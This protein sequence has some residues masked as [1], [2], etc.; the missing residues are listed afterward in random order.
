MYSHSPNS[1]RIPDIYERSFH[2]Y[3]PAAAPSFVWLAASPYLVEK[4][5]DLP[6]KTMTPS[7]I[8]PIFKALY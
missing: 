7:F 3:V 8:V 1:Q 6:P 4:L 2:S 5:D